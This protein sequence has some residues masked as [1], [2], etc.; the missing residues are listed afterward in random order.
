MGRPR[1]LIGGSLARVDGGS[2]NV[3]DLDAVRDDYTVVFKAGS[4]L[5]PLEKYLW[6]GNGQKVYVLEEKQTR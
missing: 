1:F 3:L 6:R 5:T 2:A 4:E